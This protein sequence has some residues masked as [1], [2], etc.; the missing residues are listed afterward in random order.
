MDQVVAETGEEE[1]RE[2][3]Q[4]VNPGDTPELTQVTMHSAMS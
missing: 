2:Y 1:N 3:D 4:A